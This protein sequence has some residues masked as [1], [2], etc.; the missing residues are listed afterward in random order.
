VILY[1]YDWYMYIFYTPGLEASA[2]LNRVYYEDLSLAHLSSE[3][4]VGIILSFAGG[5]TS[6]GAGAVAGTLSVAAATFLNAAAIALAAY[7]A[8]R[9]VVQSYILDRYKG[10]LEYN[11]ARDWDW[12][13]MECDY[14]HNP[15]SP[16]IAANPPCFDSQNKIVAYLVSVDGAFR[17]KLP[18]DWL[19]TAGDR[20]Y[21]SCIDL[22]KV[23]GSLY[24]FGNWVWIG[25]GSAPSLPPS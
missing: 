6:L 1:G 4:L 3:S 18:L 21:N 10:V 23:F 22:I 19:I 2:Y 9:A 11:L 8:T 15:I 14:F 20:M 13:W 16:P 17:R 5:L 25:I 7:I 12:G 24:G